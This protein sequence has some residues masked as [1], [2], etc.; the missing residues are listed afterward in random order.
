MNTLQHIYRLAYDCYGILPF[1]SAFF[2]VVVVDLAIYVKCIGRSFVM[3]KSNQHEIRA[4]VIFTPKAK[5]QSSFFALYIFF[6]FFL[7][8]AV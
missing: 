1:S 4:S 3:P 2:V 5:S 6:I 8:V 7:N